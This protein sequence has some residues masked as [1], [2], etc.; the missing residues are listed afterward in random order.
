MVIDIGG[1]NQRTEPGEVVELPGGRL[2]GDLPGFDMGFTEMLQ[3]KF[4]FLFVS[5]SP[6][7]LISS[8]VTILFCFSMQQKF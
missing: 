7:H 5:L 4:Y 3:C 2:W 6:S 1:W 8:H